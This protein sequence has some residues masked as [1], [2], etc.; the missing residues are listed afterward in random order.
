ML[1]KNITFDPLI[2]MKKIFRITLIAIFNF[3]LVQSSYAEVRLPAIVSSNM[4]LQRN[5]TIILW[6]W[7]D[8]NENITITPSW[9]NN[10]LNVKADKQGNWKI[11]VKTTNSGKYQPFFIS[12]NEVAFSKE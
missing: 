12:E 9:L 2:K 6:G 11:E 1:R 8:A 10:D 7:A 5:T 3:I 4:V